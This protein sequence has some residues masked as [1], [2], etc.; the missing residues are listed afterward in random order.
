MSSKDTNKDSAKGSKRGTTQARAALSSK[1]KKVTVVDVTL[2][3][4]QAAKGKLKAQPAKKAREVEKP[5]ARAA[6]PLRRP[7][8]ISTRTAKEEKRA[9]RMLAKALEA[10]TKAAAKVEAPAP[11]EQPITAPTPEMLKNFRRACKASR[12][13]AKQGKSVG[14][15]SGSFMAKPIKTGKKYLVDLRVHSPGTEGYFSVGGVD[16]GPAV[17]SLAKVKG[18]DVIA[19]TDYFNASYI[20]IVRQ[21][22]ERTKMNVIPGVTLRCAIGACREVYLIALFPETN[23]G[24]DIF[25]LLTELGVPKE[26]YGHGD[27]CLDLPFEEIL[28]TIESRGGV[29]IPSRLDKTPYRLLSATSLIEDYGFHAF[30]LVYPDNTEYFKDRWPGGEFTFLTFSK[31]N[32][33]GQIGSR[34]AKIRLVEPGFAGIKALVRRRAPEQTAE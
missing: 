28:K 19:V 16:P 20:D 14:K 18:L 33:L 2:P 1:K 3:T 31:A 24:A 21:S 5:A 11:I 9:R 13:Q 27:Y 17:V 8:I 26:M 15:T 12:V 29:A 10:K 6:R 23:T 30:D 22:A 7:P 4:Q 34:V 32:A 25:A